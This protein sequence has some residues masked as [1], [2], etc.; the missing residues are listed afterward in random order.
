VIRNVSR[1]V[2]AEI[3]EILGEEIGKKKRL[4]VRNW[5][6]RRYT[7]GGPALLKELYLEDRAEYISCIKYTYH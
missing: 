7:R 1:I 4:W 5:L 3:V 6:T 2:L